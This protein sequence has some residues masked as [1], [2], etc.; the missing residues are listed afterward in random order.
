MW[1]GSRSRWKWGWASR[2]RGLTSLIWFAPLLAACWFLWTWGYGV[3]AVIILIAGIPAG[4]WL[5][6]A[7]WEAQ[8]RPWAARSTTAVNDPV[9]DIPLQEDDPLPSNPAADPL[10]NTD[11]DFTEAPAEPGLDPLTRAAN[12][13]EGTPPATS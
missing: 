5:Q 13:E 9:Y 11:A 10:Y 8:L 1:W 2:R 4:I 6:W 12:A 3:L 7:L